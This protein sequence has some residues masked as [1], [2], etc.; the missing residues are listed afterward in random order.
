MFQND[1]QCRVGSTIKIF[2]AAIFMFVEYFTPLFRCIMYLYANYPWLLPR[3]A[4]ASRASLYL[5]PPR[6]P[7][8]LVGTT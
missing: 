6:P 8:V 4:E 2:P 7:T 3:T 1:T 5:V